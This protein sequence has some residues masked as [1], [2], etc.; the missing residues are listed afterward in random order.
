MKFSPKGTYLMTWEIFTTNK[1][2]PEGGPNLF[3]YK[4]ETGEEVF[5]TIQKK[6]TDWEPFWSAD[7]TL[8]CMM[9]GGEVFFYELNTPEGF[10][11]PTRKLGGGKNGKFSLSPGNKNFYVFYVPGTKGS[12]SMCKLYLYPTVN[13]TQAITC[14]SF[15]QSD[16]VEMLWNKRGTDILLLT[17]T[18]IDQT[19]ASYYGK[20]AL[21][22]MSTK[23][24]SY[25][26]TLGKEGPIHAVEWSSKSTEFCVIYGYMPATATI[27]NL[28]CDVVMDFQPGPRNSIYYNSFG[29]ILL[30]AG[31]GNLRGNI[32]V[33]DMTKK[34]L[35]TNIQAPDS[36][37]LEWHPNGE[38]FM[39]ATTAPRLRMSNGLVI[40]SKYHQKKFINK[41]L[42]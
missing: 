27:F 7:E 34:K 33:W 1:D 14:K 21:H 16:K 32:E 12:P 35:I 39:T 20:Q 37:Y 3:I 17:S 31:F 23:G 19:G 15:F 24:D 22:F 36:T 10:T 6:Q 18:D 9:L 41:N 38:V 13:T 28:K 29:N 30:L 11:T 5:S 40:L 2:N 26:V 8:L 4:S 42:F 25:S